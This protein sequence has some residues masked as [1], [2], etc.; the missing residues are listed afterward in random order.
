MMTKQPSITRG[1]FAVPVIPNNVQ[2]NWRT[3]GFS[4]HQ[5]TD[6]PGQ[7]WRD[8]VH[9][10]DELLTVIEGRLELIVDH[11]SMIVGPGD[12]AFIPR[13]ATHSVIN[14]FPGTT[15]WLFGYDSP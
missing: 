13:H 15:R 14:R 3:R 7:A 2:E 8:F 5:F 4:F 9:S 6:P 10:T 1:H 12:E 11:Q